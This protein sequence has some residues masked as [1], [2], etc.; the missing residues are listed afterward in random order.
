MLSQITRNSISQIIRHPSYVIHRLG[1]R[2]ATTAKTTYG[3]IMKPATD[4]LC[5]KQPDEVEAE[6][7]NVNLEPH[8]IEFI[9]TGS[10][11]MSELREVL[12]KWKDPKMTNTNS[13]PNTI[14]PQRIAEL[15][16]NRKIYLKRILITDLNETRMELDTAKKF[17]NEYPEIK[18]KI[19]FNIAIGKVSLAGQLFALCLTIDNTITCSV[20]SFVEMALSI[21]TIGIIGTIGLSYTANKFMKDRF[22]YLTYTPLQI[23]PRYKTKI[24]KLEKLIAEL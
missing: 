14:I 13:I 6:Y 5:Y 24:E 12:L 3:L 2:N 23:I 22:E 19:L 11:T 21:M 9:K 20:S 8:E 18:N 17:I 15:P 7:K 16:K 4:L 10:D 1:N